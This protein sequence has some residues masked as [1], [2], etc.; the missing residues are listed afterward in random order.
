LGLEESR[1]RQVQRRFDRTKREY[2]LG[3]AKVT[4]RH[5]I[6]RG[7]I[8]KIVSPILADRQR[9]RLFHVLAIE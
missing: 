5:Q 6:V 3:G 1:K 9:F 7:D 8:D 4:E 2:L